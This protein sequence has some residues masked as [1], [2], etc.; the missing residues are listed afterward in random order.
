MPK[1]I[2]YMLHPHLILRYVWAHFFDFVS[3]RCFLTVNYF[4]YWGKKINLRPLPQTFNE[5]LQ[6]LKL[7]DRK[8][9]YVQMVDK[10]EVRSYVADKIGKEHLISLLGVWDRFEDIDFD[11]LPDQ[12]VLKCTHN[13]GGI[14]ICRDKRCFN[15]PYARRKM[16]SWLG[17]NYYYYG[18][19]WPYKNVKP[20]IIAEK[21]MVDE[22][23]TELKDYKVH[24]FYGEPKI[25]QVDFDRFTNRHKR[26]FYTLS[27]E[28]QPFS[29]LYPTHPEIA[30]KKPKSLTV[31]LEFAKKLSQN[32]PYIRV[33]LYSIMQEIYF[34]ELTFY[35]GGGC[36]KFDPPEWNTF[37][38]DWL[39][40]PPPPPPRKKLV[41]VYSRKFVC[42]RD[43]AA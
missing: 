7:Y 11:G 27:W 28:Y 12:F 25:I 29:L 20:R 8:P 43:Y 18:R 26:N 38:G 19:E 1:L 10:Y 30:I 3:D 14:I 32:I 36:E 35:H 34:G 31:M 42:F 21:Y 9:E 24:C 16:K 41:L 37:F 39:V 22:S 17:H 2:N 40:L 13:S 4:L 33:D 5:K 6:W 15:M 23:G